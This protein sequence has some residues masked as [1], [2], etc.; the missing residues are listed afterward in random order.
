MGDCKCGKCQL[1]PLDVINDQIWRT[2]QLHD[3]VKTLVEND[4][5]EPIADNGATVLDL[6]RDQ[7][8]RILSSVSGSGESGNG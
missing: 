1:V 2:D 5:D 8:K 3:L 7:A 6:W 4:P